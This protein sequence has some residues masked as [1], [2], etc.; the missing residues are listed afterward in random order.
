MALVVLLFIVRVELYPGVGLFDLAWIPHYF[1]SIL[2]FS[3]E[4]LAALGVIYMYV[5]GLG[6]GPR[7]QT[8]WFIGFQFRLGIVAFFIIFELSALM[9]RFDPGI[10]MFIYFFVSLFA[11]ALA[12]MEESVAPIPLGPRWAATLFAAVVLVLFLALGVIQVFTL[13]VV[14]V[15][16]QL[17]AIPA[18]LIVGA[19]FFILVIPFSFIAD[20]LVEALRPFMSGLGQLGQ[21]LQNLTPRGMQDAIR[22]TAESGLVGQLAPLL[23][24]LSVIAVV[25]GIGYLL[26]RA[27]NLRM[28]EIEEETY[29]R[30]AIGADE[31]SAQVKG[32]RRAKKSAPRKGRG[33]ISA[34]TIR[35]VY[36]ALVARAGEAGL[37][38]RAAETP[39]EFLP[40]LV[41]AFP[42]E[43]E[44]IRAI[45]EAYIAVHYGEAIADSAQVRDVRQAWDQVQKGIKHH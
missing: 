2:Q 9:A 13:D 40:R 8:L 30:E 6:F 23:K 43:A 5:R 24:G 12:R 15:G 38:R 45:T 39:Y 16:V 20:R 32:G 44:R 37:P 14:A 29:A 22:Q 41:S 28:L 1:T 31:A 18:S 4:F 27:L 3:A 42:A 21:M 35:R 25:V 36:A 10:W 17:L 26:A 11:I 34:E 19:I 7:P 33:H